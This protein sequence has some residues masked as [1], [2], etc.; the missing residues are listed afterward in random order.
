MICTICLNIYKHSATCINYLRVY[1]Y[2][3]KGH[4]LYDVDYVEKRTK[5]IEAKN[6]KI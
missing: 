1:Y 4:Y 6:I 3:R 2:V 5:M